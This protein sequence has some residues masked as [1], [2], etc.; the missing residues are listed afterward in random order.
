MFTARGV[1]LLA[2]DSV[3]TALLSFG[4]QPEA[5]KLKDI[6]NKKCHHAERIGRSEEVKKFRD[7]GA[8]AVVNEEQAHLAT[9]LKLKR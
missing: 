4:A 3:K 5:A 2:G 1:D 7:L 8:D 6:L 9:V